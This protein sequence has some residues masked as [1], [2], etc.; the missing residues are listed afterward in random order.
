MT[1]IKEY[2]EA[3][4]FEVVSKDANEIV[5]AYSFDLVEI[6]AAKAFLNA[7]ENISEED[8]EKEYQ[9]YLEE[10][11]SDNL[12][13]TLDEILDELDIELSFELAEFVENKQLFVVKK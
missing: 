13:D 3:N 1:N 7:E 6:D 4:N 11:A 8:K 5:I 12:E 2:L 10:I 9:Q